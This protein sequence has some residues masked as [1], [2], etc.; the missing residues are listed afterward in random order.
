MERRNTGVCPAALLCEPDLALSSRMP[1]KSVLRYERSTGP[2]NAEKPRERRKTIH[3]DN[4]SLQG[5]HTVA[6]PKGIKGMI[7]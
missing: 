3:F 1:L 4:I 2:E 7:E 6:N 5:L